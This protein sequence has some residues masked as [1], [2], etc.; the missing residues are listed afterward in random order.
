MGF[1]PCCFFGHSLQRAHF[2]P[3]RQKNQVDDTRWF[4]ELPNTFS[5]EPASDRIDETEARAMKTSKSAHSVRSWPSS[6]HQ[7]RRNI[8]HIALASAGA[9]LPPGLLLPLEQQPADT[10]LNANALSELKCRVPIQSSRA[11][12]QKGFQ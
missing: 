6:A 12:G 9:R 7:S 8:L 5:M 4:P 1:P 2:F 10:T 11:A 3:S